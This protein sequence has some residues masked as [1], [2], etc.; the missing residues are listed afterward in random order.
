[1]FVFVCVGMF[2]VLCLI[3][4]VTLYGVF[5]CFVFV[6][7][8]VFTVFVCNVYTVWRDVRWFVFCFLLDVCVRVYCCCGLTC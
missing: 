8:P 4:C 3:Y 6:C 5:V 1:M 2:C 7:M